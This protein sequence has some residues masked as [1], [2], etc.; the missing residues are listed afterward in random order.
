MRRLPGMYS[1]QRVD[2]EKPG[3]VAARWG[4]T[5]LMRGRTQ[6]EQALGLR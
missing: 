4:E 2:D 1:P 6:S 5:A 3:T